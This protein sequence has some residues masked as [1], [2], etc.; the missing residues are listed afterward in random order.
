M[1]GPN[2]ALLCLSCAPPSTKRQTATAEGARRYAGSQHEIYPGRATGDFENWNL[3]NTSATVVDYLYRLLATVI[4]C[5][6]EL[7][8]A[9]RCICP[10]CPVPG[11]GAD[12]T[13]HVGRRGGEPWSYTR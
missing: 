9:E 10:A 4:N 13:D 7:Q 3:S 5:Q 6:V 11:G 12:A 8:E 1:E 2:W